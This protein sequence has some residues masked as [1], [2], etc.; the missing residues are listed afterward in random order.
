LTRFTPAAGAGEGAMDAAI[1]KPALPVENCAPL[2]QLPLDEYQKVFRKDNERR[3]QKI[4]IEEPDTE[5]N[6]NLRGIKEKYVTTK[7][8]QHRSDIAAPLFNQSFS[9]N[10]LMDESGTCKINSK[11]IIVLDRKVMQLEIEIEAKK[12]ERRTKLKTRNGFSQS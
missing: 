3:F 8:K 9:P 7:Y 12:R 4:I 2:V 5:S 10:D 1:L 6:F 11:P